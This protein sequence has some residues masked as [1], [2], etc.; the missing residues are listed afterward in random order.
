MPKFMSFVFR[1]LEA[2]KVFTER[3][4]WGL[5]RL[6]ALAEAFGWT[7]LIAGILIDRTHW[8]YH[9]YA[10]P[11]AGQIHGMI[12]LSYFAIVL[13][14]YGSLG[15]SRKKFIASLACG[16]PPYGTL[17]FE[18]FA[19]QQR[20][21]VLLRRHYRSILLATLSQKLAAAT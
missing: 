2:N 19:R 14:T 8:K 1:K 17:V 9:G 18:I 13:V 21:N 3:E 6:F 12:F 11:I 10:V 5:F 7:I 15:W 20:Q 16:V 4:A